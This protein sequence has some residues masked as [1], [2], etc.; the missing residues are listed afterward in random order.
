[1]TFPLSG[2]GFTI[3]IY[4]GD[5]L[6]RSYKFRDSNTRDV[7]DLTA[8]GWLAWRAQWRPAEDW[9]EFIEMTVDTSQAAVGIISVSATA[10]QTETM[11]AGVWDLQ[12]MRT[13][14]GTT[15]VRTWIRGTTTQKG[16]VTK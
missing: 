9:P 8:A 11:R 1:M 3:P 10:L 6:T 16:D 14:T 4:R 7:I 13:V 5:S 2:V 15:E 12:A